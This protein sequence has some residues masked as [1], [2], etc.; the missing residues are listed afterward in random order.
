MRKTA[1][2]GKKR[3]AK[4][5]GAAK[6]VKAYSEKVSDPIKRAMDILDEYYEDTPPRTA[7]SAACGC[8]HDSKDDAD[9]DE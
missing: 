1:L 9:R 2:A 3:P 4:K 6:S 5:A 8:G 7:Q